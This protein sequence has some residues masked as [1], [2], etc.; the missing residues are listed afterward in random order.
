MTLGLVL[1][2]SLMINDY[3]IVLFLAKTLRLHDLDIDLH[4]MTM[5]LLV[6]L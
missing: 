5:G 4:D 6:L 2:A 1:F 3:E